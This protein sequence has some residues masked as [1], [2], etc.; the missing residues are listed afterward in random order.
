[1]PSLLNLCVTIAGKEI[2]P[3]FGV[4]ESASPSGTFQPTQ[5]GIQLMNLVEDEAA[6]CKHTSIAVVKQRQEQE[7]EHLQAC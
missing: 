7:Q 2:C 4:G 1:M 3:V 5:L 6:V